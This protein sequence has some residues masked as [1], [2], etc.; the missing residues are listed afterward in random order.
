M[1]VIRWGGRTRTWPLPVTRYAP[2]YTYL[3]ESGDV[4]LRVS[5]YNHAPLPPSLRIF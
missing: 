1:L 5:L 4:A 2:G 3:D